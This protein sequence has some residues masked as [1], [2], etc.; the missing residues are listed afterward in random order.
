MQ[1]YDVV[2]IGSGLGG[3]LS[4]VLLAKEGRHV[5]VIEQNKQVGGCLQTFSFEKKVFD[6][7]VHYIGALDEG[8]TQN[9]IF[10]Y[11]GIMD[12]LRLKKLDQDGF[13][14]IIFGDDPEIY[15]HAQNLDHFTD[16]LLP[17]FENSKNELQYYEEKL[18]AVSNSFPLY[19]LRNGSAVEKEYASDWSMDDVMNNI[20]NERLQHVL[21]GNNLLYAGSRD[22]TPFYVHALVNKSYIDSA[23]KCVG[24][25]SQISKLLWKKLQEYGGVIYRNEKVVKLK[26][27]NGRITNAITEVGNSYYGKEFIANVHPAMVLQWT[28]SSLIK[29][30]YRKRIAAADNSISAFM[31]NIVLKPGLIKHRNHNIYWNRSDDSYRA[32][33]YK[34][35]D[36]PANYALYF[37]E[38]IQ[39]PG[40]SDTV[41]VLTYMHAHEFEPWNHTRN[42]TAQPS[43]REEEYHLFKEEK[44]ARLMDAVA[45]RYPELK[46]NIQ[47]SQIASPLTFRDYMGSPDGSIYGIMADVNNP[48]QSQ[49]PVRT[50][51]PN[52]LLTGQNIGLH[53]VLG[54]SINAVAVCGE[55]L[56]LD[57]LLQKINKI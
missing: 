29:P 8:Q 23:Y 53:G 54:V 3:L 42:I 31:V 18:R 17:Y 28:D 19:N 4:A 26:E 33:D 50:K 15:P 55:L 16:T 38:D 57:Y 25:S 51:I 5:A 37:G 43:S 2:I 46:E 22:K 52:L 32:I 24:G 20:S 14:K 9:S 36:W 47:A 7:C 21:M 48:A 44:A 45:Q 34:S 12:D 11:A 41:A 40:Y 6:S 49:V 39:R 56:G 30:V 35:G 27:V 1:Q 10:R 13:D